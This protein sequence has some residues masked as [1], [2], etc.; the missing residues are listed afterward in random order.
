MNAGRFYHLAYSSC[1]MTLHLAQT[2]RMRATVPPLPVCL[3]GVHSDKFNL[4]YST[5]SSFSDQNSLCRLLQTSISVLPQNTKVKHEYKTK[6]NLLPP[7]PSLLF[8]R[9]WDI[10][11]CF[12]LKQSISLVWS[13]LYKHNFH[14]WVKLSHCVLLNKVLTIQPNT[15]YRSSTTVFYYIP[16]HVSALWISHCN[17]DVW[18]ATWNIKRERPVFTVVWIKIL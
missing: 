2:L 12:K 5:R 1:S 3:S 13:A 10:K 15:T 16:Q 9:G 14:P 11:Y 17:E 7:P 4:F 6:Y 8:Q 18:H